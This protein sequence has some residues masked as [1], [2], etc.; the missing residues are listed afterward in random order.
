MKKP[1]K[2]ILTGGTGFIGRS[3]VSGLRRSYDV[4][5]PRREDVDL[6]IPADV[7]PFLSGADAEYLVHCAIANPE[8]L[9]DCG[10]SI[11]DDTIRIFDALVQYPFRGI[12]Y[13]GSGAEYDKSQDIVEVTE[14]DFGK[15]IP[16]DEYGRAKYELTERA[17][18]SANVYNLRIFGCYGPGEPERRFLRHAIMCCLK[19]EE[20]TI[21]RDCRFSYVHVADLGR[22]MLRILEGEPRYHDYNIC[23]GRPYRL[24][25]LAEM[26]KE[27]TGARVPIRILD[28]EMANEYTGS[29][30]RFIAEFPD[31]K[32]T[33]IDEGI[34]DEIKWMKETF[35]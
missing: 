31:F 26:V 17:R 10:K 33:P 14:E 2:L 8:K 11:Y 21:R 35:R 20:L 22:A 12:I 19:G 5:A 23:G 34:R 13:I 30:D 18:A 32:W 6:S 9:V 4:L 15:H 28:D 24:S 25:E 7:L 27:L 29:D 3:I 16:A 1:V